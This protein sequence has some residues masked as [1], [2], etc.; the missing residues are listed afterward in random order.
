[1]AA[2]MSVKLA[3]EPEYVEVFGDVLRGAYTFCRPMVGAPAFA[4][5]CD[6]HAFLADKVLRGLPLQFSFIDH[7]PQHYDAALTPPGTPNEFGD[8]H[9]SAGS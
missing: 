2:L 1:M 8:A 5:R 3:T 7:G 6:E 9:L 4:T